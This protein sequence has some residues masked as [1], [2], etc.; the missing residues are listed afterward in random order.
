MGGGPVYLREG[1]LFGA[2]MHSTMSSAMSG[3]MGQMQSLQHR[4][5][6]FEIPGMG[7]FFAMMTGGSPWSGGKGIIIGG[8]D[9]LEG[10]TGTFTVGDQVGPN[11]YPFN[12]L[13]RF[14]R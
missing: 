10:L 4:L 11:L 5:M 6:T 1:T 13:Y 14:L 2:A 3:M 9:G 8:T 12:I 7:T